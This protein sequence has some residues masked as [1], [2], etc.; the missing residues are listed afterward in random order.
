[1][2]SSGALAPVLRP[3]PDS[4]PVFPSS[5]LLLE[6]SVR[7]LLLFALTASDR[8][9]VLRYGRSGG[10]RLLS[11]SFRTVGRLSLHRWTH[12]V[13]QVGAPDRVLG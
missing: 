2:V 11:V 12:L 7:G 5:R 10:P 1:M 6:K 9:V 8:A 4:L 3:S 13:L